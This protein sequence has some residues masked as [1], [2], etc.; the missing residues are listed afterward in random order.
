MPSSSAKQHRFMEAIAHNPAFAKKA[1]VPQSVG[2]DF[3]AADKGKKFVGG[4]SARQK[5][6]MQDTRHGAMDMPFHS[7]KRFAGMKAGGDIP[8][9]YK[10]GE[11]MNPKMMKGSNMPKMDP[12][13]AAMRRPMQAPV[14][15]PTGMQ[16][17]VAMPTGMKSGGMA[18]G[19]MRPEKDIARDQMAM[20]PYARG[21]MAKGGM[22]K[23][24]NMNPKG[25]MTSSSSAGENTKIQ[26]KGLTEGRV[27]KMAKGGS[28]SSRADGIASKGKTNCKYV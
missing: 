22:A 15:M 8:T 10:K 7:L 11:E 5:I 23:V 13:M 18:K 19:G 1:G 24:G 25:S 28:V 14:A 12:R 27:I 20:A 6:N 17:P 2:K 3:A 26:K 9:G 16:A 4:G 21:G